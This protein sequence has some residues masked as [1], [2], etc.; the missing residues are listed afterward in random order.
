[1]ASEPEVGK[2]KKLA[3]L[4][5]TCT[6]TACG[7]GLHC[8]KQTHREGK[9]RVSGGKCRDCAADLVDFA[10]VQKRSLK[11]LEY[12]F[13]SLKFELIRHHFWHLEID[14]RAMNYARRK[15]I[16]GL[17]VAAERRIRTSVGPAQPWRDGTQTSMNGNPLYYPQ[18][19][20]ATC[21]RKCIEYW[22][23]VEMN[24]PLTEDEVQYFTVLLNMFVDDRIPNLTDN[25]EKVPPMRKSDSELAEGGEECR[26]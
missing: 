15:G 26:A 16:V 24:R 21:C 3:P 18:H 1:M 25:G 13:K 8:F 12:T 9:E 11:D 10:R 20:T 14:L 7:D 2:N 5:I 19:A 4:K 22:H 23:G 17:R 6:S